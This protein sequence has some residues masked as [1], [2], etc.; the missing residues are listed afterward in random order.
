MLNELGLIFLCWVQMGCQ[1]DLRKS[2]KLETLD[3]SEG[4]GIG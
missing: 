3:T 1:D 2:Q 4:A